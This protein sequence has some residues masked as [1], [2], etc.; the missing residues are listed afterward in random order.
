[1]LNDIATMLF[2]LWDHERRKIVR[3]G[4]KQVRDRFNIAKSTMAKIWKRGRDRIVENE[5]VLFF[6]LQQNR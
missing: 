5:E 4:L 1:M 2:T 6:D 3:G